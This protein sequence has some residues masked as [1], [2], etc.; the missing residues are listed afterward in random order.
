MSELAGCKVAYDYPVTPFVRGSGH[1]SQEAADSACKP[2]TVYKP[3][4]AKLKN[5]LAREGPVAD[6]LKAIQRPAARRLTISPR[7]A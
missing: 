1:L 5:L 4:A 2:V 6:A 7:R 3:Q